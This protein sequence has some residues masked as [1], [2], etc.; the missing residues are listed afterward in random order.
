[1]TLHELVLWKNIS[2][3]QSTIC[4]IL[5]SSDWT[6]FKLQVLPLNTPVHQKNHLEFSTKNCDNTFGGDGS[7]ILWIDIDEKNFYSFT[8][9]IVYCPKEQEH[10]FKFIHE[11]S[12]SKIESVMFF[13]AIARP[14]PM[15]N[16][17]GKIL[18]M[19]VCNKKIRKRDGKYG[20]KGDVFFKKVTMNKSLF[21]FY[22]KEYL[23]P[24]IRAVSAKLTEVKKVIVQLD[25]AGSHG[26]GRSDMK[27]VLSKLNLIGQTENKNVPLLFNLQGNAIPFQIYFYFYSIL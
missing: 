20:K 1:M 3:S 14:R 2:I 24:Q 27:G 17:D 12:K 18:L 22:I 13:C 16:F 15:S 7:S 4:Q 11:Q 19:P 26:G 6:A 21:I 23:L 25:Q 8:K 5:K 10:M 9:H